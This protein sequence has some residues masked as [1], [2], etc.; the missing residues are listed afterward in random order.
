MCVYLIK[1]KVR[2]TEKGIYIYI[3]FC[4]LFWG[5]VAYRL[6]RCLLTIV[7]VV[8]VVVVCLLVC[9]LIGLFISFLVCLF[10]HSFFV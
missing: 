2:E 5:G 7:V 8:V 4:G 10:S 6:E 3:F 1:S 9:V